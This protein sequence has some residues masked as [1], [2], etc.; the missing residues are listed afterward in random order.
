MNDERF[1]V[2]CRL[3][4]VVEDFVVIPLFLEMLDRVLGLRAM[5]LQEACLVLAH[6]SRDLVN[7]QIET[8]I[9]VFTFTRS[10]NDD[11]VG[12]KE[13]NFRDVA[14]LLNVENSFGFDDAR[15]VEG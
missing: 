8:L 15:I 3:F 10:L 4:W 5:L 1:G 13:K 2:E 6:P 9:H 12:A 14:V 11:M 7:R